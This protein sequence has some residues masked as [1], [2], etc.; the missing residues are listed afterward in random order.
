MFDR[1]TITGITF[2]MM[3]GEQPRTA[4]LEGFFQE[5]TTTKSIIYSI[6]RFINPLLPLDSPIMI[7]ST[8]AS[9][10][11]SPRELSFNLPATAALEEAQRIERCMGDDKHFDS[12]ASELASRFCAFTFEDTPESFPAIE[13]D[14]DEDSLSDS[15]RS[16]DSWSSFLTDFEQ[17][18]PPMGKRGRNE[19]KRRLVRSKEIKSNLSS[20]SPTFT[21]RST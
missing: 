11:L 9:N 8:I 5:V 13:W 17:S 21:S 6:Q 20:L 1:T 14:S 4:E 19:E 7:A 2:I 15:E 10:L 12:K 3:M 18:S 16:L